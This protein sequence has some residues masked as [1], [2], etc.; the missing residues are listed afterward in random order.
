MPFVE[1]AFSYAAINETLRQKI[2]NRF[3]S[4]ARM[5]RNEILADDSEEIMQF[6]SLNNDQQ[7]AI[8]QQVINSMFTMVLHGEL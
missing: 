6:K 5:L 4:D 2:P 8:I 3:F 7:R 1:E